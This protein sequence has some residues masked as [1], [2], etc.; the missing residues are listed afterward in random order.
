MLFNILYSFVNTNHVNEVMLV[1]N[2][3]NEAILGYSTN[4]PQATTV[5]KKIVFSKGGHPSLI[6]LCKR[7]RD[8]VQTSL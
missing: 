6:F 4:L 1:L 8:Q 3:Q 5:L 2:N 7:R